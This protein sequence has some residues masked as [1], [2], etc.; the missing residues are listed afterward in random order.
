MYLLKQSLNTHNFHENKIVIR[1]EEELL[2][3]K[4]SCIRMKK[5]RIKI[6]WKKS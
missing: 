4:Y 2:S 1:N 5:N 6:H 3:E